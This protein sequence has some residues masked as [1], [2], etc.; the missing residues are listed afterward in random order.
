MA[1]AKCIWSVAG[2]FIMEYRGEIISINESYR[3]VSSEYK[4]RHDYYF[5]H[6]YGAEVVD[7]GLQGN[8]ARY[9]NH[10]CDPNIR[11]VRWSAFMTERREITLLTGFCRACRL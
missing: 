4:N 3:R 7:A 8:E 1:Q 5:L 2:V 6:Y 9:I 10:S 11:V